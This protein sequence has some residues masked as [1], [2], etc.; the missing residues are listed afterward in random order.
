ML[1]FGCSSAPATEQVFYNVLLVLTPYHWP[2]VVHHVGWETTQSL[3]HCPGQREGGREGGEGREGRGGREG[4][5][6]EE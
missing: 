1:K 2:P 3:T 6:A 5:V 4:E